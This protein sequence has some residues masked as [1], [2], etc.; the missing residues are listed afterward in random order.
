MK[1]AF[2]KSNQ[3]LNHLNNSSE[4]LFLLTAAGVERLSAAATENFPSAA[5]RRSS[6]TACDLKII[7]QRPSRGPQQSDHF[8]ILEAHPQ[9]QNK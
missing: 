2:K 6:R 3:A 9:R 7:E 8:H 5:G 4:G 1:N